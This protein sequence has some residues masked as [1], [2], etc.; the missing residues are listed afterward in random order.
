MS[1]ILCENSF[2][3]QLGVGESSGML[4]DEVKF[5]N[6]EKTLIEFSSLEL[7]TEKALD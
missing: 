6:N 3:I 4:Y 2:P 1:S 5:H 7:M